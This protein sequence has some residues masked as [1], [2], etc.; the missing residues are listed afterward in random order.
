MPLLYILLLLAS[1]IIH[2]RD[3]ICMH[4]VFTSCR[5][6][7]IRF[8]HRESLVPVR[9]EKK[10]L[11]YDLKKLCGGVHVEICRVFQLYK[12]SEVLM[13][14]HVCAVAALTI[15]FIPQR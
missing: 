8:W 10:N 11:K 1:V 3:I 2:V 5:L 15:F 7:G 13:S 9:Y 12:S 14:P 6:H 4:V